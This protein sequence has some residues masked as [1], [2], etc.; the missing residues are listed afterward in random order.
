MLAAREKISPSSAFGPLIGRLAPILIVSWAEAPP[1]APKIMSE[2][3]IAAAIRDLSIQGPPVRR[4]PE[5]A[6]RSFVF[7]A[8]FRSD[9]REPLSMGAGGYRSDVEGDR[10]GWY[11]AFGRRNVV[12]SHA[13]DEGGLRR[14]NKLSVLRTLRVRDP[15]AIPPGLLSQLRPNDG[16]H[17]ELEMFGCVCSCNISVAP[18]VSFAIGQYVKGATIVGK[19]SRTRQSHAGHPG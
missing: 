11:E 17:Q 5:P 9:E 18:E 2:A 13:A 12:K 7:D 6:A 3:T 10:R 14:F 16:A 19:S 15:I 8:D 4:A 1:A